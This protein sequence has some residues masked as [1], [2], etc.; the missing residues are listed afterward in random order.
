MRPLLSLVLSLVFLVPRA[1]LALPDIVELVAVV[2]LGL[3]VILCLVFGV[4]AAPRAKLG[5]QTGG[6]LLA[7][8]WGFS[9]SVGR[10]SWV[11]G[12]S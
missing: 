2:S 9:T 8:G 5:R 10:A 6:S 12:V 11:V 3:K 7:G 1:L 4:V